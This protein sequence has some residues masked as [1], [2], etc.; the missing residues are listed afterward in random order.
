MLE[1]FQASGT[2]VVYSLQAE[3]LKDTVNNRKTVS[4]ERLRSS[5]RPLVVFGGR[6]DREVRERRTQDLEITRNPVNRRFFYP[7]PMGIV[8]IDIREGTD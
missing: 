3:S 6:Q 5:R 7:F 2:T 8:D 4:Y 1:Y